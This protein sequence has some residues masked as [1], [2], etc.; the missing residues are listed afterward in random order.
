MKSQFKI[1]THTT[2]EN[3]TDINDICNPLFNAFHLNYFAYCQIRRNRQLTILISDPAWLK[4]FIKQNYYYQNRRKLSPGFHAWE[5]TQQTKTVNDFRENFNHYRGFYLVNQTED[6]TE[7]GIFAAPANNI[8]P[9]D[10]CVNHLDAIQQFMIYFK[11]QAAGLLEE[12]NK[13]RL[14]LNEM[15]P[16]ETTP[17]TDTFDEKHFKE[18]ITLKN[19]RFHIGHQIVKL[20]A[21]EFL[22]VQQYC[23]GLSAKEIAKQLNL[24][25]R[26]V[27]TYLAHVRLKLNCHSKRDLT[28]V[29][30]ENGCL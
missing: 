23:R 6:Y 15:Q 13:H 18:T 29:A 8:N 19:Y 9:I 27:E 20:T 21:R 24:S 4:Q 22:C 1:E 26:S 17:E 11:N 3:A 10:R 30:K 28:H 14:F 5:D 25:P 2:F 16:S 12:A 7:T